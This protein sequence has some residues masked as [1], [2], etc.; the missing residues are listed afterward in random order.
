MFWEIF[1]EKGFKGKVHPKFCVT[2]VKI[3]EVL[4]T[5]LARPFLN[6]F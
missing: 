3:H 6:Y 2:A 1:K 4:G 5:E